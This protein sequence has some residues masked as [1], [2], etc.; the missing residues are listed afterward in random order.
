[1]SEIRMLMDEI[2]DLK[3][4]LQALETS[5][6]HPGF[7]ASDVARKSL[8]LAQFAA[9]TS[10]QL[11]GV[12]SDETGSGGGFVRATSPTLVTPA[13]GTPTALVGTNITGTAAGLTAGN[14]TTNA[15][16]TGPITS[17][18][19]ATAIASQ[20]G[21]GT[22]FVVDTSPTLVTPVLGAASA[23]S[24]AV[25]AITTASGALTVTPAAGSGVAIVLSTTGDFVVNTNQFVVDTSTGAVLIGAAAAA[26]QLTVQAGSSSTVGLVVSTAASPS[27]SALMLQNNGTKRYEIVV[28][29]T[30]YAIQYVT[31]ITMANN[32]TINLGNI[33]AEVK[34]VN[35]TAGYYGV[36]FVRGGL[37]AVQ[38]I[39][40][41]SGQFSITAGTAGINCYYSAGAYYVQN[42][43][44]ANRDLS[45]LLTSG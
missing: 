12:L 20:T 1:M 28:V 19:N 6:E 26:G 10:A 18:G 37:N 23:T 2:R 38:E 33:I 17:V 44:G 3:R 31:R 39:S 25:P 35:I 22:K 43:A 42:F 7:A 8:T 36:F 45:I 9:T 11:A 15:N 14:V 16:L 30:G 27:V 29:S 32:T 41:P 24:L 4:R 5:Q 34:I 21:T 40:D 13:L